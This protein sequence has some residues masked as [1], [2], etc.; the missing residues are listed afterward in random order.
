MDQRELWQLTGHAATFRSGTDWT[1][2]T[3]TNTAAAAAA[4]AALNV[5]AAVSDY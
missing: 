4:A 5:A 3:Y 2:S 1:L